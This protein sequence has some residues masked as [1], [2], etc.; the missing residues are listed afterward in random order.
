VAW[1]H[2]KSQSGKIS[3][4]AAFLQSFFYSKLDSELTVENFSLPLAGKSHSSV[5]LRPDQSLV[6]RGAKSRRKIPSYEL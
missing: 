3:Q 6:S 4:N 2:C 5:K 1:Q